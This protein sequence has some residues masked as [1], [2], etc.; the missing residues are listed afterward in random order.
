MSGINLLPPEERG[1]LPRPWRERLVFLPLALVVFCSLLL[2]GLD[3]VKIV[4]LQERLAAA[5]RREARYA[6]YVT[7]AAGVQAKQAT[8]SLVRSLSDR[9]RAAPGWSAV[10]RDLRAAAPSGTVL[11]TLTPAKS[12]LSLEGTAPDLSA[13]ALFLTRVPGLPDLGQP[14]LLGARRDPAGHG[15]AFSLQIPLQGSVTP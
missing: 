10:L 3:A 2:V 4:S 13:I 6:P 14:S 11:T 15:F 5:R 7:L 12:V 9:V 8:V 1:F